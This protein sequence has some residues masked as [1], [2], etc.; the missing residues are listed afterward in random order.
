[1]IEDYTEDH[2][3]SEQEYNF[4]PY[5]YWLDGEIIGDN[6]DVFI[7]VEY[8]SP[9]VIGVRPEDDHW[10]V[11]ITKDG[12]HQTKEF[13]ATEYRLTEGEIPPFSQEPIVEEIITTDTMEDAPEEE[14]VPID[15]DDSTSE[16]I[17]ESYVDETVID[18]EDSVAQSGA[19]FETEGDDIPE[20]TYEE[21]ESPDLTPPA[22]LPPPPDPEPLPDEPTPEDPDSGT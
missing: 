4:P 17:P 6:F 10:I 5:R 14:Q 11:E 19:G 3:F 16:D 9:E 7:T 20:S 13:F 22:E 18:P 12:E 15:P 8:G 1:M 21:L 2:I